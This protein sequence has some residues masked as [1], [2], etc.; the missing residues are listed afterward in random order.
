MKNN[1]IKYII[2]AFLGLVFSITMW[3]SIVGIIAE[4][5]LYIAKD[6]PFRYSLALLI[7]GVISLFLFRGCDLLR[8]HYLELKKKEDE[9]E[10]II[11]KDV[12]PYYKYS[13]CMEAFVSSVQNELTKIV[14]FPRHTDALI[15]H[16]DILKETS[17]FVVVYG[18]I[19]SFPILKKELEHDF[20][21]IRLKGYHPNL[22]VA[23]SLITTNNKVVLGQHVVV[24]KR[25]LGIIVRVEGGY[26]RVMYLDEKFA[27]EWHSVRFAEK[28]FTQP[29][30]EELMNVYNYYEFNK[31]V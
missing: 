10:S 8:I 16:Y 28:H 18:G 9:L 3:L 14:G 29:S 11:L 4:F 15:N 23:L 31:K 7:T 30:A 12:K 24:N 19:N 2:S 6:D 25:G 1:K 5:T 20:G 27:D 17:V 21:G 13:V 22:F 26:V